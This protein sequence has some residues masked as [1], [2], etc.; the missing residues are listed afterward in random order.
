MPPD[1]TANERLTEAPKMGA[2]L[3]LEWQGRLHPCYAVHVFPDGLVRVR[4]ADASAPEHDGIHHW[5][6]FCEAAR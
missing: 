1:H 5:S 2:A 3:R 6:R 4:F